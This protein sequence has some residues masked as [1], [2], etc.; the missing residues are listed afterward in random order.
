M[1]IDRPVWRIDN[2]L[3][4]NFYMSIDRVDRIDGTKLRFID[5][6]TGSES[7]SAKLAEL[8]DGAKHEKDGIFQLLT[9]CEAYAAMVDSAPDITPMLH[10]MRALAQKPEITPIVLDGLPLETYKQ[11]SEAFRPMLHAMIKEIFDPEVPFT[12]CADSKRCKF[13]PFLTLCGSVVPEF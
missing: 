3:A 6:K 5:F 4:V 1:K 10:P 8:F 9:Y 7:T 2:E 12:Q 11:V 13:C